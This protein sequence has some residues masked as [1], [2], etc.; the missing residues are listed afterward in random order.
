MTK[1][2]PQG[3]CSVFNADM[4]YTSSYDTDPNKDPGALQAGFARVN[5]GIRLYSADEHYE[6]AV[7]GR[8]LANKYYKEFTSS[9][10]FA[11]APG[12]LSAANSACSG[13]QA[14]GHLSLLTP[15]KQ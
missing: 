13:D 9:D 3:G 2:C 15:A 6:F 14:S 10:A 4:N 7:I 11:V 8:D 5:A 12:Q 1:T